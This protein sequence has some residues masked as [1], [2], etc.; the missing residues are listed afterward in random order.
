MKLNKLKRGQVREDGMIFWG[1]GKNYKNNE[2]WLSSEQFE[3][4]SFKMRQ[5]RKEYY[6]NNKKTIEEKRRNRIIQNKEK[7]S[8]IWKNEREKYK[9]KREAYFKEYYKN[10]KEK[11]Y[12]ANK[13]WRTKNWGRMCGL[14]AK[15][16]A[17]KRG[18]TPDLS[19]ESK[20]IVGTI[21]DQAKRLSEIIGIPFE[22]DH[23]V[24]I[25]L[26]GSH[27]PSN[28]QVIPRSI[29]RKKHNREIFMWSE[30]S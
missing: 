9:E 7:Y 4:L 1:Y 24:P 21:F 18:Q 13:K 28:L 6:L 11:V 15:Y 29:N 12:L 17:K 10:N 20:M 2:Y 30:K 26:G 3:E 8:L 16:R 22:V 5:K 19:K 27:A 14:L 25:S 23:I